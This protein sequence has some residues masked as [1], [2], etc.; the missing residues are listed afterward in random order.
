[1]KIF[2]RIIIAINTLLFIFVGSFGVLMSVN[3]PSNKWAAEIA[4]IAINYMNANSTARIAVLLFSL[5]LIL[6]AL[7]TIVGNIEKRKNERSVVLQSPHGDILVS[8]S[9]IEDFSRVVKN[10][11]EGVRDIKGKVYSK[12]KGL[13]VTAKVTL[14]SDRS[15]A[16][17]TQEVQEAIIRYI[18]YTLGISAEIKPNILVSKVVY[19]G[20]EAKENE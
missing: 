8:L 5:I 7:M 13:D 12:R 19:K 4:D 14:Y 2:N 16:D 20:K 11:V 18:Q 6:I 17:V 1:M 3:V 15:V 10:Q 9:A